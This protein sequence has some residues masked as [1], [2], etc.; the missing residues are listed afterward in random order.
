MGK[1]LPNAL[2]KF[3]LQNITHHRRLSWIIWSYTKNHRLRRKSDR[4]DRRL[5]RYC[6]PHSRERSPRETR[7]RDSFR[8]RPRESFE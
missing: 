1:G 3:S 8:V 2:E 5:K 7:A 4:T 6:R